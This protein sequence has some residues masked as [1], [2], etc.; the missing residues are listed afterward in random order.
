MNATPD[1]VAGRTFTTR[2]IA[3]LARLSSARVRRC[4]HAGFLHP[5]RGPRR[6]FEYDLSDLLVL[7]ATRR[8]LD[9]KLSPRRIAELVEDIRSQLPGDRGVASVSL[10]VDGERVI[11]ADGKRRWL[12][13]G[14]LLLGFGRPPER[15]PVETIPSAEDDRA[16]YRAFSRGLELER[17][18][19][20]AATAAYREAIDLDPSAVPAYVNLGRLEHERG[21]HKRAESLY[22]QALR[23]DPEERTALFN[24]AVLSEDQGDSPGAIRRYAQLLAVDPDHID[25][26]HCLARLHARL[27][28]QEE[29]RRHT[30]LC[31]M[32]L[33]NRR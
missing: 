15:R 17:T 14:Q 2:E 21:A 18:S 19:T 29:S 32:L 11:I 16:A 4:V 5:R 9:A 30:R 7:R 28:N 24:L 31:R 33:R 8:L 27:G 13:D 23:L 10:S 20:N 12:D 25:G 6:R 1:N 26:H 22:Q 3:R